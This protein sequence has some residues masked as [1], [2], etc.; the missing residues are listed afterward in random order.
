MTPAPLNR[1]HLLAAALTLTTALS[2]Q[3]QGYPTK[4]VRLQVPFAAGGT[5][6]LVA[7]IIA[8]PLGKILGQ[9]V[10]VENKAG[11]GGSISAQELAR[12][13]VDPDRQHAGAVR[14]ADPRRVRRLQEGCPGPQADG[15]M[16]QRRGVA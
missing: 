6:D 2:A 11:A 4:P 3:A 10:V 13:H 9:T 15:R 14:S 16:S 5:T 12:H 7:R 1:R 8:E